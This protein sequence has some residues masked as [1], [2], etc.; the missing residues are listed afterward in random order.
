MNFTGGNTLPNIGNRINWHVVTLAG[1]LALAISLMV[2]H[3]VMEKDTAQTPAA[4]VGLVPTEAGADIEEA[5]YVGVTLPQSAPLAVDSITS[6]V[7][8]APEEDT[9]VGVTLPL[10]R[11]PVAVDVVE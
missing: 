6:Q 4:A 5:T 2:S 3:G 8:I 9:Y 1:G 10:T 11:V 7:H